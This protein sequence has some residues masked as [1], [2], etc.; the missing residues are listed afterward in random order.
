MHN[1]KY[2]F[3]ILKA[4]AVLMLAMIT[5][6]LFSMQVI[7]G[8][9]YV[10][11]AESRAST[12]TVTKAPRGDILDKYGRVLV[13]NK[14]GYSVRL[15]KTSNDNVKINEIVSEI[16]SILEDTENP[17]VN[18]L[19]ITLEYPYEFEF[20]DRNDNDSSSDEKDN[21]FE[22]NKH[23]LN[24]DMSADDVIRAY[25]DIYGISGDYKSEHIRSMVSVR[26]ETD[27][28]QYSSVTPV[29]VAEDINA[30]AITAIKSFNEG[31]D[32]VIVAEDYAR[33]YTTPGLA[34][35]ILGRTGQIS[36]DEYQK[37]KQNG[38]GIN[39]TTVSF[40]PPGSRTIGTAP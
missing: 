10:K 25:C 21:W 19:P 24:S 28:K 7:D 31:I 6:R 12:G 18:S 22:N 9:V 36:S 30:E 29:T 33:A 1:S 39:D 37:N 13:T 38:Y 35:H 27:V 4:A 11:T 17:V 3:F 23:N 40:R 2:R 8:E 34:T 20:E 16:V 5:V 26:Y 32:G 15:K 14:S